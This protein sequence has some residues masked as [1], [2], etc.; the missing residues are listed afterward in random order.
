MKV[1]R[2]M[3]NVARRVCKWGDAVVQSKVFLRSDAAISEQTI[4]SMSE[5]TIQAIV[6]TG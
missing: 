6:L 3:T 5:A 4:A 2:T 1:Q